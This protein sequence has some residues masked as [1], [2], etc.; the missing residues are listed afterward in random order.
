MNGQLFTQDFLREGIKT[1]PVWETLPEATLDAFINQLQ[2]I[3]LTT[4]ADS[5]LNEAATEQEISLKY[6]THSAGAT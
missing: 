2:A 5:T 4:R 6:S 3:Y 1:T